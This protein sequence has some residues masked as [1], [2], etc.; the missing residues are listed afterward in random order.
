[1]QAMLGMG[2]PRCFVP[3]LELFDDVSV[4][5]ENVAHGGSYHAPHYS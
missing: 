4:R 1:V 3:A 5:F 2:V